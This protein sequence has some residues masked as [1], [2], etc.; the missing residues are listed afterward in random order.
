MYHTFVNV[1]SFINTSNYTHI[2]AVAVLSVPLIAMNQQSQQSKTQ[3]ECSVCSLDYWSYFQIALC[4]FLSAT[5]THTCK[6]FKGDLPLGT[7]VPFWVR[8]TEPWVLYIRVWKEWWLS[9]SILQKWAGRAWASECVCIH[10][11]KLVVL[12]LGLM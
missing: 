12:K 1:L 8:L 6:V 9:I 10:R 2:A 11:H 4:S 7:A 3:T 5:H